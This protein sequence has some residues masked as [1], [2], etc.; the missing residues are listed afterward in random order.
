MSVNQKEGAQSNL[1]ILD[2]LFKAS[3][4][5]KNINSITQ[6]DITDVDLSKTTMF[7]LAHIIIGTAEFNSQTITYNITL[8]LM[9]IVHND[10]IKSNADYNV[11]F[12]FDDDNE[13]YVLN[14]MLN[15]GN[16]LVD[17]F[18][19]G[20]RNDGNNFI[21]VNNVTAEPFRE[22]FENNLAGWSFTFQ[23]V[24]RNNINRCL[25]PSGI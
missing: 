6:G 15:V 3:L 19:S 9:D 17:D 10:E 8:L 23:V 7:P 16:H 20:V 11:G 25:T 22:R 24:T 21:D 12:L 4:D 5:N 18:S 1:Q 13:A 14:T 2:V